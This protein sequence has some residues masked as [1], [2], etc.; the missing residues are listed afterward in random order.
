MNNYHKIINLQSA[1]PQSMGG[2]FTKESFS[3]WTNCFGL[4]KYGE[5]ILNG[6]TNYQIMS[7]W[8]RS[9]INGKC[10]FQ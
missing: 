2:N 1:P 7:R 8:G 10:I 6:R 3:W 5:V 9:F 4:K